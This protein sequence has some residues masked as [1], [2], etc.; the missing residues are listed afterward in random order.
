MADPRGHVYLVGAGPGEPGLLTLRGLECL[1]KADLIIYD[2]LVSTALLELARDDAQRLCVTE[3]ASRHPDRWPIINERMIAA[4]RA[5]KT[6]VRL[7][8]G[9]PAI[10]AHLADETSALR[11]AGVAYEIVPGVT[12]ALGAAAYS[13]IP[14]T[15]RESASAVAFLTGHENPAKPA[16]P[17]D[18]NGFARFP[19][20]LVLYMSM[21]RIPDIARALLQGGK[22]ATTPVLAIQNSTRGDQQELRSTLGDL[23]KAAHLEKLATPCLFIIGPVVDLQPTLTWPRKR[24]LAGARVLVARPREQGLALARRLEERGAVA[25]VAPAILVAP[26]ADWG[27]VDNAIEKL[28]A[29]DWI[30]FTS[31]NGVD[32]FLARLWETSH[33]L[34]A[35]GR[36]RLAAI[37][38]A[39]A[40]ALAEHHLRADLVPGEF[41]SETLA[42]ELVEK[43]RGGSVL[44]IRAEQ[45]RDVLRVSLSAVAQV[46]QVAVYRQ[47][48]NPALPQSLTRFWNEGPPDFV[49]LTSSNIA[50]AIL[51]N[52]HAEQLDSI[53][54]G[55]VRLVTISPVTSAAVRDFNLQVAGEAHPYTT[56]GMLEKLR[57]LRT[58]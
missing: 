51:G 24:P 23:Q 3:L 29:F 6:V 41:V 49:L 19:G 26:P 15:H 11:S 33:D 25:L 50:R 18:W 27:R 28:S 54:S 5:G 43:V 31:A 56:D 46:E 57:E 52:L 17:L 9:D 22:P 48:K 47:V 30:V 4:A 7:K 13:E 55:R 20:T 53:R 2:R 1:Q 32:A 10:F 40:R 16:S 37:G 12:A 44:L 36:C 38:P 34:R 21:A 45:G 35:L 39:T 42:A 58:P 8:G 14:L